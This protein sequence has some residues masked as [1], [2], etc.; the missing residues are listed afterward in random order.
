M[1]KTVTYILASL[2]LFLSAGCERASQNH[3]TR[4]GVCLSNYNDTF[5][6]MVKDSMAAYAAA[7]PGM[8]LVFADGKEDP[9]VQ[10]SQVETFAAQNV[11]ALI[12]WA[13]N[14]EAAAPYNQTA[15][16]AGIPLV[17][18]NRKPQQMPQE[19]GFA[20][21][22]S[23]D[24]EAGRLQ[25]AYIGSLLQ[26]QGSAAIL[27]GQLG[28]EGALA[29]TKA[30]KQTL[31]SSYP[32]INIAREQNGD[33]YRDRGLAIMENWL[34]SGTRI[35]AVL[36]N[37]DDMALGALMAVEEAGLAG[38]ILIAGIDAVPD[39]LQAVAAGRLA[40]TVFQNASGQGQTALQTAYD[41]ALNKPYRPLSWIPF[42]LV[43]KENVKEFQ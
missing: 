14:T 30:V 37:N 28:N 33:W 5:Q 32:R 1:R 40:C 8:Q 10:L 26:G 24:E 17:Y 27:I 39:A 2:S 23:K 20:F 7:L 9:A 3:I 19:K 12:V 4:I 38:S 11:S 15:R 36:A 13:V 6:M 42:R 41:M 35:D 31:Q 18:L 21:V 43:T 16:N 22:G 25:A 34:N 29:R